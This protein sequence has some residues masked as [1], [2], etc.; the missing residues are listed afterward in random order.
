MEL[1]GCLGLHFSTFG[2]LLGSILGA[3]GALWAIFWPNWWPLGRLGDPNAPP[4]AQNRIFLNFSLPF[5]RHF[6]SILELKID[7]KINEKID[8]NLM[9]FLMHFGLDFGGILSYFS[10]KCWWLPAMFRPYESIGPASKIEGRGLNWGMI[11]ATKLHKKSFKKTDQFL[12]G[13]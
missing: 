4:A 11:L 6:G 13:F 8:A 2:C 5:W 7:E 12:D 1:W 3:L 10:M 9:R